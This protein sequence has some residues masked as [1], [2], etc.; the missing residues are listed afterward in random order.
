MSAHETGPQAL[1]DL[2]AKHPLRE[3]T[4]LARLQRQ[5]GTLDGLTELD[6]AH[7]SLTEITDQN[8]VGGVA[9]VV[10]LALSAAI[11]SRSRVL[12]AGAGLGG[13]ARCLA[14]LFGC[15]VDGVELSPLRAAEAESLTTRVQLDSQ[16]AS[17]CGDVL[18]VELPARYYDVVWGQ[19]A[20]MHL[21]DPA[22]LFARAARSLVAQGRV[23]FEEA[24][25]VDAPRSDQDARLVEDLAQ[26][27]GGRFMTRQSWHV[28]MAASG[29][30]IVTTD[31][32]THDFLAHF[33]RLIAI[34]RSH[35]S[36]LYPAHETQA[37]EHAITLASTGVIGYARFV[38]RL[39][40]R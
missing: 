28:A 4:I 2:Y 32:L 39:S 21:A 17:I 18:A 15:H 23:A 3:E 25:L 10:Q 24:I 12:D 16:V 19:G 31:D 22:A 36:S 1:V 13:S 40:D 27:W 20:W 30:E 11:H 33:A 38:A 9:A 35:G 5:R 34:A 7:D 6:L 29:F 26:L 37:F 14:Y 8:H